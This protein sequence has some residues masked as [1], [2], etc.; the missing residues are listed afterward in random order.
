MIK[1]TEDTTCFPLNNNKVQNVKL[2]L[3]LKCSKIKTW[4]SFEPLSFD[5]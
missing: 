4:A 1:D 5:L 3:K 2:K